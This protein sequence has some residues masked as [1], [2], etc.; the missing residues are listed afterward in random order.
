MPVIKPRV[1]TNATRP[2]ATAQP[3]ASASAPFRPPARPASSLPV[4]GGP[5]SRAAQLQA[6]GAAKAT[7][8]RQKAVAELAQVQGKK[9][10]QS[11]Y[12]DEVLSE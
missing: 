8:E 2:P 10:P 1:A 5:T 3:T 4:S 7:K 12:N 11:S 6:V 9:L